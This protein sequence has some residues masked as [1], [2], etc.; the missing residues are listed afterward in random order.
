MMWPNSPITGIV[1]NPRIAYTLSF[2]LRSRRTRLPTHG[3]SRDE[4]VKY[5]CPFNGW[6]E[7]ICWEADKEA[8]TGISP[9]TKLGKEKEELVLYVV[10]RATMASEGLAKRKKLNDHRC[11]RKA[12]M[13]VVVVVVMFQPRVPNS[14]I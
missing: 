4:R 14:A 3:F 6:I 1:F 11:G 8:V 2:I 12:W 13:M 5:L 7:K 9:R 10:S